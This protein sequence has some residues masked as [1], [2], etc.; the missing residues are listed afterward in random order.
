MKRIISH[1][2]ESEQRDIETHDFCEDYYHLVMGHGY[3][4]VSRD[5]KLIVERVPTDQ[6][7]PLG[8]LTPDSPQGG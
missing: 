2:I 4:I 8:A 6:D 1:R 5:G 7:D 3:Q